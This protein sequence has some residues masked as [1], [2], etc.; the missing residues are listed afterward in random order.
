VHLVRRHHVHRRD[1]RRNEA[2]G[3]IHGRTGSGPEAARRRAR[4][5]GSRSAPAARPP[6][7]GTLARA[8]PGQPCRGRA[9]PPGEHGAGGPRA[10]AGPRMGAEDARSSRA[11]STT[12]EQ[13]YATRNQRTK[14]AMKKPWS[15]APGAITHAVTRGRA[16]QVLSVR[17][18]LGPSRGPVSSSRCAI[19]LCHVVLRGPL[20]HP[21]YPDRSVRPPWGPSEPWPSSS[22]SGS[23][24]AL[25]RMTPSWRW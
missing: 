8:E 9:P 3:R 5:A 24:R 7:G 17:F 22:C 6:P 1:R 19:T 11:R 16:S 14:R 25:F 23:H 13:P 21:G 4:R 10:P 2:A 20:R 18:P 15:A 12:G